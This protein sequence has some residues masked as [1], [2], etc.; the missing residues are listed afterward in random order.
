MD[1]ITIETIG[2]LFVCGV[3]TVIVVARFFHGIRQDLGYRVPR[4]GT[5]GI[6]HKSVEQIRQDVE[7]EANR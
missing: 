3:G 1:S 6:G 7:R 2:A 4:T 5:H